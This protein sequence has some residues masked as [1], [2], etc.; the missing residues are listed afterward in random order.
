MKLVFERSVE[1]RSGYEFPISTVPQYNLN[2]KTR[3]VEAQLPSLCELDVVRHFTALSKQ[4]YG[5]DEGFYPLGSCT[6]KYNPKLNEELARLEGFA[7]VHPTQELSEVKG[8]LTIIEN[9][10]QAL[11]SLTG[12]DFFTLQ[13]SAGAH[14][15]YTGMMLIKKYHDVRGDKKRTKIIIPDSAHGTN[16]ASA[17]MNGFEVVTVPSNAE[18]GVDIEALATLIGEDTAGL[19]L[20]NP[21]TLGLFDKNIL[22]ITDM[23]HLVGGLCYYDGANLNAV[24]GVCRPGDMGFDVVHLNVHKT[25]SAPHGGGGPGSG[26]VGCKQILAEFLPTPTFNKIDSVNSIGKV[27]S[28]FGNFPVYLRGYAYML[29]LGKEGLKQASQLAVLNANYLKLLLSK[30]YVCAYN[31]TCMHEFVLDLSNFKR[32]FN[33]SALDIAKAMMDYKLHPP[34]MYFPLIVHE[35]LMFEPTETESKETL[36][37]VASIM[38][39]IALR[40]HSGEDLHVCPTKAPV[41]RADEVAAARQPITRYQK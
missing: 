40:A 19:M 18:G 32:D 22:K 17:N 41:G 13:P 6:M 16:P 11:C 23:I 10:Q 14:G 1:G 28:F 24:M 39:E 21:N 12:M 35:A 5:V 31:R 36:E 26:P 29:T 4:V 7:N 3:Q 30:D 2:C 15:E 34:T 9:M 37:S 38:S 8:S 33:T 27:R 20:T 25:L